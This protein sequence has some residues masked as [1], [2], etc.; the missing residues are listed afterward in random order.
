MCTAKVDTWKHSPL[1]PFT[2]L[3]SEGRPGGL[4]HLDE[5]VRCHLNGN[6]LT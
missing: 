2:L 3:S 4:C 1:I 5:V 6:F